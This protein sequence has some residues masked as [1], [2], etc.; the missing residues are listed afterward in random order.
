M[1]TIFVQMAVSNNYRHFDEKFQ[2]I[3][4]KL[5]VEAIIPLLKNA[6]V[7]SPEDIGNLNKGEKK[8][9]V[10]MILRK[11]KSHSNG[12]ELFKSALEQSSKQVNDHKDLLLILYKTQGTCNIC[13]LFC[14]IPIMYIHTSTCTCPT[15][16]TLLP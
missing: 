13:I 16:R 6:A 7:L 8:A 5:N 11:V 1:Y 14:C 15:C 3:L 2:E 9:A 10:K 4:T 12:D